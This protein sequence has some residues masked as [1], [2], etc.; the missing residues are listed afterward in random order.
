MAIE[1]VFTVDASD[2][3]IQDLLSR[4]AADKY[5]YDGVYEVQFDFDPGGDTGCDT[6]GFDPAELTVI[7]KHASGTAYEN[8]SYSP[9]LINDILKSALK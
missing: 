5:P 9:G 3:R 7:I 8:A 6:C 1:D 4:W 2:E